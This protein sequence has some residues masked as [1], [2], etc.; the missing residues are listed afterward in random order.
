MQFAELPP[1]FEAPYCEVRYFS[2]DILP[3]GTRFGIPYDPAEVYQKQFMVKGDEILVD[4]DEDP[5]F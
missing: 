4:P 3:Y 5:P 1:A 2:I